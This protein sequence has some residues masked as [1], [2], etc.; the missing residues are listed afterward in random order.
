MSIIINDESNLKTIL[1]LF[2]WVLVELSS[3]YRLETLY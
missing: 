1:S 3:S 2:N